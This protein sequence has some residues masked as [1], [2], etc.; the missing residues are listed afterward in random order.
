[1][2][3]FKVLFTL[4]IPSLLI[5][6][7]SQ[8]G[9]DKPSDKPHIVIFIA[10]DL[11]W[12]DVGYHGSEIKTPHI[13]QLAKD[14]VQLE[15]FYVQPLCSPTRSSLMTGRYPIRQGL[16][17]GVILPHAQ[18]GLPLEERTLPQAL[19]KAG[20][21]T[22]IIGK[23]HLGSYKPEYLPLQRGFDYHYGHYL[24][25][26]DY[27]THTRLDGLD[28]HRN[29]KPVREEGYTTNLLANE[30][31][32]IISE[33]DPSQPLFLYVPFNAVHAPVQ[34]PQEYI[35]GYQH[36]TDSNRRIYA[37]MTTCMDEAIGRTLEALAKRGMAD[38]TLV[39][40]SSDNGGF[41]KSGGANNDPLR[42]GKG[43][44]YEGGIRVPALARWPGKLKEGSVVKEPL[45][46][47]DWYP[48][49]LKLAGASLE[50]TLPL[51]GMDAWPTIA[52]GKPSPHKEILHNVLPGLT[53]GALR[54]GDW[55]LVIEEN[56]QK[57]KNK[58]KATTRPVELFNIA[59]DPSE[60]TNLADQYPDK[61]KELMERLTYYEKAAVPPQQTKQAKSDEDAK[62]PKVW[63]DEDQEIR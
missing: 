38:N 1:M 27:F 30:A 11:G 12:K 57:G 36:I 22:V 17:L 58:N 55:K 2:P 34:A 47:V 59:Q 44:L 48:T 53:C 6:Q 29:G 45:H 49:L 14:G 10:D 5:A 39:L 60:R 31:V 24:G 15:Q 9:K 42:K 20:Y 21:R 56:K 62:S 25:A 16:Q 40:F 26:I 61:V 19:K 13:D 51:D 63:G 32:K 43:T 54:Q 28:W 35:D 3:Y 7:P 18:Y 23:W 33:H 52:L 8:A 4:I 50:Q 37:A 46:I 41:T